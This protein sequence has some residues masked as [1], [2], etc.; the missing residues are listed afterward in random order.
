M[1]GRR[2]DDRRGGGH[3]VARLGIPAALLIAT[4]ACTAPAGAEESPAY[5]EGRETG[6]ALY[7]EG[8]WPDIGRSRADALCRQYPRDPASA[9]GDDFVAGCVDG[10]VAH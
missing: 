3:A 10:M 4:A 5:R 8:A 9:D 2:T 7:K 1:I 6:V